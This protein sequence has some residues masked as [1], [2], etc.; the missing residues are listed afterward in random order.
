MVLCAAAATG[1]RA[2]SSEG[3]AFMLPGYG[4]RAA[5]MAGAVVARIDD[6]G[7]V[8]WNPAGVARARRTI[9][10]A[11]VELVPEAFVS[12]AQAVFV[13][14]MGSRRDPETGVSRHAGGAM[15]STLSADLGNGDTY[16]ENHLRLAYAWSAQPMVSLA[17]G[18]QGF[19]SR[20]GVA[21]FDAWGTAVDIAGRL[22]IT[23]T[24]SCAVVGRDVFSR[25]SYEDKR[26]FTKDPQYVIGL[27]R[28]NLHGVSLEADLVYVHEGW[29]T[30]RVGAE[31]AY[32]FG[33]VALRGG[34]E[35]R[36]AGARRESYAFG[37]S[38]RAQQLFVHYAVT[39]DDEDALG[40]MH[41]FSLAVGL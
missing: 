8:D 13:T 19:M 38:V 29:H 12:Q 2:D 31:T 25:Y 14:P 34:A 32:V 15:L 7:A 11:Y 35:F 39:L 10:L 26:N 23:P 5:G 28:E 4:A 3:G 9:G 24:W 30:A 20:S 27:A 22:S 36:S 33:C 17:F 40:T 41:R 18:G 21:G 6:E 1:A 16:R 37:A